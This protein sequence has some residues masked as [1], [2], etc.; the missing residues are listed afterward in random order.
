MLL[1]LIHGP[2][3]L[4]PVSS[5]AH[6][7]LIPWFAGWRYEELDSRSRK[8][9][10]VALHAGAVVGLLVSSREDL[11]K[12]LR[13]LSYRHAVTL[14]LAITPAAL[15]G[16]LAERPVER[17]LGNPSS[18][19]IALLC[20]AGCMALADLFGPEQRTIETTGPVDGILLGLAQVAALAPGVSRNGATLTAARARGLC[21]AD[22]ARLSWEAG[23]PVILGASLLRVLRF[24]Q[25][26]K[27]V[28]LDGPL[29][30]G[31]ASAFLSSV[32]SARLIVPRRREGSLLPYCAYRVLLAVLVIVK[33]RRRGSSLAARPRHPRRRFRS[34]FA[35]IYR[36]A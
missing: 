21:R 15:T 34:S 13:E 2:T 8:S 31:A 28:G 5:S 26:E 16:Y 6:T 20:G 35:R 30:L 12:S 7:V 3:E 18:I 19:S 24:A 10:E 23:I 36:R 33:L 32:A 17:R 14:V 25:S 27:S 29:L 11:A 1:G 22:A 4:L 9:F